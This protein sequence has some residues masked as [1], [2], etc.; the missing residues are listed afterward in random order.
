MHTRLLTSYEQSLTMS[1]M[2]L[3][4]RL[5]GLTKLN[6]PVRMGHRSI[7]TMRSH[8]NFCRSWRRRPPSPSTACSPLFRDGLL[9]KRSYASRCSRRAARA[10]LLS[11]FF[12]SS[13]PP[14]SGASSSS[15]PPNSSSSSSRSSARARFEG[16]M[17][18]RTFYS[19]RRRS[20][21]RSR[22]VACI[23]IIKNS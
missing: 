2:C 15:L 10:A 5:I 11:S 19:R 12:A 1:V 3:S 14:L 16:Y 13:S 22:G 21:R 9:P 17:R 6:R 20:S 4:T 23:A 7:S 8:M 18:N